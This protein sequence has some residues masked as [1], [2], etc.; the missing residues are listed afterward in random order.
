MRKKIILCCLTLL[1]SVSNAVARPIDETRAKQVAQ[2]WMHEKSGRKLAAN[3]LTTAFVEKANSNTIYYVMNLSQGGWVIIAGDDVAYPVVAFSYKGTYTLDNHPIQFDQWMDNV[4]AEI[5]NA[6]LEAPV[7]RPETATAWSRLDVNTES[8][9]VEQLS[10]SVAPLL[11]TTWDQGTYYNASCP[12]DGG[13]PGGYVWAG[14][15]ATAMAQVMKYHN[16]PE[17]GYGSHSYDDDSYGSQTANFGAT[18]YNWASMPDSLS[19]HNSDVATLLYHAGVSVEMDYGITGSAASTSDAADALKSYFKYSDQLYYAS[20]ASY[21]DNE[22]QTLLHTELNNGRP[23]M[24]RGSGTGGHAFLCDGF[25]ADDYFHFNWGWSGSYNGY[26]YLNDL[27]PGSHDYTGS[28]A[29]IFGITPAVVNLTY[30]Y[31][32]SFES[33]APSDIAISGTRATIVTSDAHDGTHSLRL[34]TPD[35]AGFYEN[36]KAVLNIDVPAQGA[37][38]S[39]WVKRGYSPYASSSNQ[40]SAWLE[41]QFG[42]T[43][44]FSFYDGDYN[45]SQWVQYNQD[46]SPWAGTN[47]KLI[48][49]QFNSSGSYYEWTYLDDIEITTA[50]NSNSTHLPA[51]MLLLLE[52]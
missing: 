32:E 20:K 27:T 28:Q 6:I 8:F 7:P 4:T 43:Q 29:G 33:G 10:Y 47:I 9:A 16:Y 30:P 25:S 39:F 15:V 11:T 2:N 40:Q 17:T 49:N 36:N 48:V 46:L 24:Y 13:G 26:F 31:S 38:L 21:T 52:Q 35:Q 41:T 19:N 3:D 1:F 34:S 42:G 12:V 37:E 50:T 44:L 45:D 23:V 18:T 51:I 22:W 14:C 5:H